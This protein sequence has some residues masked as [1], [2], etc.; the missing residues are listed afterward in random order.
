MAAYSQ[1]DRGP[2]PICQNYYSPAYTQYSPSHHN[3]NGFSLFNQYQAPH[4]QPYSSPTTD[5]PSS[6]DLPLK[7][8]PFVPGNSTVHHTSDS[9]V[10]SEETRSTELLSQ[11]PPTIRHFVELKSKVYLPT[12]F[13]LIQQLPTQTVYVGYFLGSLSQQRKT[14]WISC[15][16]FPDNVFC[17]LRKLSR[18]ELPYAVVGGQVQFSVILNTKPQSYFAAENPRLVYSQMQHPQFTGFQ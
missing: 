14:A 15:S 10:V 12:Y 7:Y 13:S 17:D 4:I 1:F 5:A 6:H 11:L 9:S 18:D 16:D 2:P 8:Q 3:T